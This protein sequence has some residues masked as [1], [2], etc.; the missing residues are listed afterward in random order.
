MYLL[1][2][3]RSTLDSDSVKEF[4]EDIQAFWG[5]FP[6]FAKNKL[7][8]ILASLYVN[9]GILAYAGK[10]GFVVIAVGDELME[11]KNPEDSNRRN[12]NFSKKAMSCGEDEMDKLLKVA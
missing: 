7:V 9:E 2:S 8:G 4:V 5:F 12:G 1:D 6:E 11:V 10:M 3:T